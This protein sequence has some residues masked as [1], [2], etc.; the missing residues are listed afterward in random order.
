[1]Q[2]LDAARRR[3]L[4]QAARPGGRPPPGPRAGRSDPAAQ[5]LGIHLEEW[6]ASS[7]RSGIV[8]KWDGGRE[9]VAGD[10][11]AEAGKLALET[12]PK[13]PIRCRVWI[14]LGR[15]RVRRAHHRGW[16]AWEDRNWWAFCRTG[17]WRGAPAA[18]GGRTGPPG[19][20]KG[21]ATPLGIQAL[22]VEGEQSA[23]HIAGRGAGRARRGAVPERSCSAV[24]AWVFRFQGLSFPFGT[25]RGMR[26]PC[27]ARTRT[28]AVACKLKRGIKSIRHRRE[29]LKVPAFGLHEAHL[30]AEERLVGTDIDRVI[31]QKLGRTAV[32]VSHMRRH[33]GLPPAIPPGAA[34]RGTK[35]QA[36]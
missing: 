10:D 23:G 34:P 20:S 33:L 26:S 32:S 15:P 6:S 3:S 24:A 9:A 28:L 25:G 2:T 19:L 11:A 29:L 22:D 13:L 12:G 21:L 17:R 7:A 31:A 4:R 1:M 18:S 27:W 30:E 14:F 5:D 16:K 35:V 36:A 8:R